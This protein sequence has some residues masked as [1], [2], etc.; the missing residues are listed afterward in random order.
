M[1]KSCFFILLLFIPII[2]IGQ[3]RSSG[4]EA[5]DIGEYKYEQGD[6]TSAFAWYKKAAEL[7]YPAGMTN[8]GYCYK[9]G[10]GTEKDCE[11]AIYW[12][13][14]AANAGNKYAAF[15]LGR[16]YYYGECVDENLVK[17]KEWMRKAADLGHPD[18][19]EWMRKHFDANYNRQQ[20]QP[21]QGSQP[22][23]KTPVYM[24]CPTCGGTLHCPTCAGTG[25]YW[26]GSSKYRCGVCNGTGVCQSCH[27]TGTNAVIYY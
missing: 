13:T 24:P 26:S 19:E 3:N 14:K 9:Y 25:S 10:K 12:Y 17:S 27:G 23:V 2:A 11:K 22:E 8:L 6:Y 16:S 7:G 5:F 4:E 21:S 15:N 20:Q 1:K 18:A